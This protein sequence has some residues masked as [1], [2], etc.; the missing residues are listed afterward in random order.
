MKYFI[1]SYCPN[2]NEFIV[3]SRNFLRGSSSSSPALN[4]VHVCIHKHTCICECV[5]V[6]VRVD[7][8]LLFS[9]NTILHKSDGFLYTFVEY[10][11][12]SLL[13]ECC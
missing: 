7:V 2:M 10:K 9:Y 3:S 12:I 6:C 11:F 8:C 1:S 13:K 4:C 5:L